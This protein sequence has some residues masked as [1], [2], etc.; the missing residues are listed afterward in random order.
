MGPRLKVL[1]SS[2][3]ALK[4]EP[5]SEPKPK[6]APMSTLL[7]PFKT[8]SMTSQA[9]VAEPII[10]RPEALRKVVLDSDDE[11]NLP[12]KAEVSLPVTP[13]GLY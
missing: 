11:E 8:P 1:A 13:I 10:K 3:S 4:S 6:P 12:I 2:K 7:K 5:T 9:A